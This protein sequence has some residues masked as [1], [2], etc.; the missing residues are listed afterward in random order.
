LQHDRATGL[1][2]AFGLL[3]EEF[4][5]IHELV[6][7]DGSSDRIVAES[8]EPLRK[9]M[10]VSLGFADRSRTARLG[11][12]DRCEPAASGWRVSIGLLGR[13]AG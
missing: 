2:T 13:P 12:I 6:E 9:G 4:G 11:V 3:A 1:I 10:R 7:V 5:A 8:A